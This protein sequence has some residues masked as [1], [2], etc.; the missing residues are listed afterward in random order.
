MGGGNAGAAPQQPI[1]IVKQEA[2]LLFDLTN[3][4]RGLN[5]RLEELLIDFQGAIPL[6]PPELKASPPESTSPSLTEARRLLTEAIDRTYELI[7]ATR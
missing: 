3:R 6:N 1:T 2:Q 5:N 4:V 7:N